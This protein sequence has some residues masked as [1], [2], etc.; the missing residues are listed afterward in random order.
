MCLFSVQLFSCHSSYV[1][2][3]QMETSMVPL[4][5]TGLLSQRCSMCAN[6]ELME[7][8]TMMTQRC[9]PQAICQGLKLRQ[10]LVFQALTKVCFF[11]SQFMYALVKAW[12]IACSSSQSA[13]VII[14]KAKRYLTKHV[15]FSGPCKSNI[16]L[17]VRQLHIYSDS[18]R[19]L[20]RN[21]FPIFSRTK[22]PCSFARW[23]IFRLK[24]LWWRL[25]GDH[26][27]A[28]RPTGT[29]FCSMVSMD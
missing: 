11:H 5:E 13:I 15:T 9:F 1:A 18:C 10:S 23:T 3:E 12:D 20:T 27:G 22:V 16:M 25:Q 17:M 29:G 26:F 28:R 24:E 8:D 19:P 2:L 21:L 7:M 14:P 4:V 6:M